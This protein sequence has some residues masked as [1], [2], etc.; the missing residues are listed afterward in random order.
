MKK[1]VT[2][3]GV[4]AMLLTVS[5]SQAGMLTQTQAMTKEQAK[6]VAIVHARVI[7]AEA[8][9]QAAARLGY[10]PKYSVNYVAQLR[11]DGDSSGRYQVV[12][13]RTERY[14]QC[15]ISITMNDVSGAL[16]S[17]QITCN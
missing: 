3:L 17:K 15:K 6:N 1:T 7:G 9:I 5:V 2:A 14:R 10:L 11:Y 4:M 13:D 16:E 12:V 8:D